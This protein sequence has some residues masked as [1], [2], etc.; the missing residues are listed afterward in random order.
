MAWSSLRPSAAAAG[1]A[2]NGNEFI[3]AHAS[4]QII[5]GNGAAQA[6][7]NFDER[8]VARAVAE[9]VVDDLVA[10]E[11]DIQQGQR[12]VLGQHFLQGLVDVIAVRQA[13]QRIM[14]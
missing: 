8:A 5:L 11:V 9:G 1:G 14:Q 13:G 3:A 4:D 10:I 12:A 2:D 6:P 7:G